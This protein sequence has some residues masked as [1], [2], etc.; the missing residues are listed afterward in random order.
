MK[1]LLVGFA[2]VVAFSSC[3]LSPSAAC[4]EGAKLACNKMYTCYTGVE[5]DG[6]KTAMGATEADCV[7]K[8]TAEG[9]CDRSDYDTKPCDANE[10]Y[11]AN[12][13]SACINDTKAQTCEALKAGTKVASC[14]KIC[15]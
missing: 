12:A 7:T 3:G 11:D 2:A 1:T 4:K 14:D 6:I 10:T 13:A 9:K 5:L 15:K 8:L